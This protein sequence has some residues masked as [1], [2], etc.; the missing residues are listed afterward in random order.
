M[1]PPSDIE[2]INAATKYFF[3][4]GRG[5]NSNGSDPI[6]ITDLRIKLQDIN[7]KITLA[8]IEEET[9]NETYLNLKKNP[10]TYGLFSKVGLRT[11]QDWVL[12]Y[13][14]FSY[15]ILSTFIII[16]AIKKSVNKIKTFFSVSGIMVG[17]G[18]AFFLFVLYSA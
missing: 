10:T 6:L 8:E 7:D 2:L 13:F 17:I 16:V 18:F 9:Y 5:S 3:Y 12:A 14:F 4:K 15:I 11:T 1:S